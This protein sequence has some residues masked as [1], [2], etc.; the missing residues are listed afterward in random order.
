[1]NIHF[2]IKNIITPRWLVR[3]QVN[4]QGNKKLKKQ[5]FFNWIKKSDMTIPYLF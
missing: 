4:R 2:G 3:Q 1:M 5:R